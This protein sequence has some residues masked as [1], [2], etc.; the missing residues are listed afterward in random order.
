[1]EAV[2]EVLN[3]LASHGIKLSIEGEAL[4]CY[5]PKG[6]LTPEMKQ[7]IAQNKA[8]II[9]RL[10][11]Y[12]DF[13]STWLWSAHPNRPQLENDSRDARKEKLLGKALLDLDAEAVLDPDI[14]PSGAGACSSFGRGKTIFLTGASGFLGAY[15]LHDLLATTAASVHCL[16]RCRSSSDGE[17]RIRSNLLKYGLWS[18]EFKCR[19][20]PVPGDLAQPLLG[21]SPETFDMLGDVVDTIYHNGAVVNFVYSYASLRDSNVCGTA[22]VIR[23][24]CRTKTKPL[25]FVSTVGVFPP[26][27]KCDSTVLES[28]PPGNWRLLIAGYSQSKWVAEKLVTAAAN[29]G[30]PVRIYRP[31][32]VGGDS[33]TGIVNTDDFMSR[34]IKGCIQLGCAPDID[35][36]IEM[37][38]VDY[39]SKAIVHLSCQQELGSS[40]FHVV[41]PQYI[42]AREMFR[43]I[44]SLGYKLNLVSYPEWRTRLFEDAKSSSKNALFPLLTLFAQIPLGLPPFDC[45]HTIGGL[46]GTQVTC[47]AIDEN[48]LATYLAYFKKSGFLEI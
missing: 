45:R 36:M 44:D 48:L 15:L 21:M 32:F 12:N 35:T 47:P 23:L 25:H 1:M 3:R 9:N 19:L 31:G 11:D 16:V 29:R 17:G 2:L 37:V 33:T 5:A 40:V 6:R 22:E 30:L 42:A 28:E 26:S 20:K 34:M 46:K 39:V 7:C 18:D 4:S 27:Q 13:R 14:R 24:A 43:I 38:P 8:E 10:K 41:A